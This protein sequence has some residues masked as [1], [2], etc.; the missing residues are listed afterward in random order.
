MT[1]TKTT[2]KGKN[3]DTTESSSQ[4][5]KKMHKYKLTK[6]TIIIKTCDCGQEFIFM[7]NYKTGKQ[8]PVNIETIKEEEMTMLNDDINVGFNSAHH[9]NHFSDCPL[10]DKFRKGRT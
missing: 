1:S 4:K 2:R 8:I 5:G 10:R 6:R 9:T 7:T 3:L